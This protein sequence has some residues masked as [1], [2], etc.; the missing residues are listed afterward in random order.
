MPFQQNNTNTHD[1]FHTQ[2]ALQDVQQFLWLALNMYR[3]CYM[4]YPINLPTTIAVLCQQLQETL[5]NVL[6]DDIYHLY[7]CIHVRIQA[8]LN[9]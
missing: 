5:N 7:V 3:T 1:A 8:C 4:T 2:H 6:Q 9:P